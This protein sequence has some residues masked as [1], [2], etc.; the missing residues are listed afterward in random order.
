MDGIYRYQRHLYDATRRYYLFGRDEMLAGLLPPHGGTVL[1][2]GCGTGRNLIQVARRT[3]DARFFGFDLSAEMLKTANLSVKRAHLGDRIQVRQGDAVSFDGASL[4]GRPTFDR[5]YFSYTLSMI[6]DWRSALR[7]GFRHVAR[8][9][10]LHV[11]DFGQC[12]NL[13]QS[14]KA[15]LFRWLDAFHVTP[16]AELFDAMSALAQETGSRADCEPLY[17]GYAW[18][19]VVTR[20][21]R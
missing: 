8:G 9:G 21:I 3:P 16:R 13:P 11:V 17:R 19:G 5:V 15:G 18:H 20:S 2:I 10:S 14:F 6:P 1:E 4:F 7:Q 12:E